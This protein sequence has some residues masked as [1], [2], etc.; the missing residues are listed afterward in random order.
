MPKPN[1]TPKPRRRWL[2][3]LLALLA[4]VLL[5]AGALPLL[6][7]YWYTRPA[8][9]IPVVEQALE[10]LTGCK[11]TVGH[12]EVHRDGRVRLE[13]A[14]FLVPDA[15]GK[16]AILAVVDEAEFF[17]DPGGLIDGT[18]QPDRVEVRGLS[19][20]LTEDPERGLF[21]YEQL[22][23]PQ[24]TDA[25]AEVNIPTI[26][27]RDSEVRFSAR[28]GDEVVVLGAMH[29]EG[30]LIAEPDDER[31]YTFALREID[32]QTQAPNPVGA[33]LSGRFSIESPQVELTVDRFSL[34]DEQRFFVPAAFRDLWARFAPGGQ[35]TRLQL[36][37]GPDEQNRF[38]EDHATV[39]MDF[40]N[41]ALNLDILGAEDPDLQS[42]ALLLNTIETRLT[43]LR[44]KLILED[45]RWRFEDATGRVRQYGIGLSP[46]TYHIQAEGGLAL[47]RPYD[48]RIATDPFTLKD[49]FEYL[50]ALSPLTSEGYRRFRPSG[51]MSVAAQFSSAGGDAPPD[52]G[53]QLHLIDAKMVHEMFKLPIAGLEGTIDIKP[54][55]I[56]ISGLTGLTPSGAA[57]AINGAATPASDIAE[58]DLQISILRLPIDEHLRAVLKPNELA[59]LDRFINTAAYDALV[60]QG[61]ISADGDGAPQFELGGTVDVHVPVYRPYGEAGE[62]SIVPVLNAAG[63]NALFVDFPYPVTVTS[64][65]IHIGPDFVVIDQLSVSSP[66]GGALTIDGRAD[67]KESGDYLPNLT[68][69]DAVLPADALLYAAVGGEAEALLTDLRVSGLLRIAGPIWQEQGAADPD[70]ALDI[71]LTDG[72]ANPFGGAVVLGNVRGSLMLGGKSITGLRFD[73][74]WRDGAT[75]GVEGVVA[76]G[77]DPDGKT[78]TDADLLFHAED[79]FFDRDLLGLLPEDSETH[80]DLTELFDDYAP[81]GGFDATLSWKPTSRDVPDDFEVWV[82]PDDLALNLLGGR[83]SLT[84][85]EGRAQVT[86]DALILHGMSGAFTDPDGCEGR[87]GGDGRI[88]IDDE[89]AIALSLGGETSALGETARLLLPDAAV[90]VLDTVQWD[91][92][93][94]MRDATLNMRHVGADEQTTRFT[95]MAT[96]DGVTMSVGGIAITDAQAALD[97]FVDDTP[98]DTIPLMAFAVE[99]AALNV[100]GRRVTGLRGEAHNEDRADILRSN[101]VTGS[102][103]GGTVVLEAA[104]GMGELDRATVQASMHDVI[105]ASFIEPDEADEAD[106]VPGQPVVRDRSQG[107]VSGSFALTTGYTPGSPRQGR[108]S[109]RVID[110]RLYNDNPLGLGILSLMSFNRPGRSGFD[111]AAIDFTLIDTT[112]LIN[113]LILQTPNNGLRLSGQGTVTFPGLALDLQLRTERGPSASRIPLGDLFNILGNELVGIRVDGTLNDPEVGYSVLPSTRRTLN[114]LL[115]GRPRV[116]E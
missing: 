83:L 24:G 56:G 51:T 86:P 15:T 7:V 94:A 54:E 27:L 35:V 73:A 106:P 37:L 77:N 81:A 5:L 19:L 23:L 99:D 26:R 98:D 31:L 101:R 71:V 61:L 96:F 14:R 22:V 1:P 104:L 92:A 9:V 64:G 25:Q 75:L 12:A 53:I 49:R 30:D 85:V 103:Y 110:A 47:D 46:V 40:E 100:M 6:T 3:R 57:V 68:I 76:W 87:L 4:F 89:P 60:A 69:S 79:F 41:I 90:K 33:E 91:G 39:E 108:G 48:I 116:E 50:L 36:T 44:G 102:M 67:R 16:Y 58:V 28:D 59:N 72:R 52:W 95:G 34:A 88:T 97:V 45:G 84:G 107:L 105:L 65:E 74:D 70:M 8:Q 82:S 17:G 93:F 29:L 32:V 11:V 115:T 42:A 43:D 111:Q 114:E 18:Y 62:Y 2:R 112:A 10:E 20:R 38:S 13:N 21:N 109:I 80:A 55:R 78:Q 66:T 113:N 63:L